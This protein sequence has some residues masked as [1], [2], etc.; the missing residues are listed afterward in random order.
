[1]PEGHRFAEL[2]HELQQLE[3]TPAAAQGTMIL[4]AFARH[5][6]CEH[7]ALYL[8]DARGSELRLAAKSQQCVAPEIL[9]TDVRAE[10]AVSPAPAVVV[11]LQ[12]HREAMGVL[13]LAAP[14]IGDEL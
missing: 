5:T 9:A 11:P 7:G 2:V 4:D 13:A 6:R 10:D 8:R 3:R 1:M 14:D 12:T